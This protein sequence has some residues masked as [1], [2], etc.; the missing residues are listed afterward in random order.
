M[1]ALLS[2]STSSN[3]YRRKMHT[4]FGALPVAFSGYVDSG[5]ES[6]PSV[7]LPYWSRCVK[8]VVLTGSGA[9]GSWTC[10]K[11]QAQR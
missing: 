8:Y 11:T 5:S 4:W 3:S 1:H 9:L 6:W 10:A 2:W 7:M